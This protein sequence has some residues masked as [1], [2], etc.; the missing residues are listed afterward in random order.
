[1][2]Q[3]L[4]AGWISRPACADD[5]GFPP[6]ICKWRSMPDVERGGQLHYVG[7]FA[8]LNP[9]LAFSGG[10]WATEQE[11]LAGWVPLFAC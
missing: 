4:M 8:S 10:S 2:L 7:H 1:M 5:R 3:Q 6:M 9:C 11:W